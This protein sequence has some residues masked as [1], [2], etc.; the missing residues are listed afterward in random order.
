MPAASWP[1]A[2]GKD[3]TGYKPFL[4]TFIRER[5]HLTINIIPLPE[6][7]VY[8]IDAS[9]LHLARVNHFAGVYESLPGI[10]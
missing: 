5:D 2:T 7:G 3:S 6:V 4:E 1:T 9:I 8:E 10:L